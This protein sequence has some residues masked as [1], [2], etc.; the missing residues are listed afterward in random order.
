MNSDVNSDV[1]N[2]MKSN[3]NRINQ[4]MLALKESN[5]KA[6]V[7][8][9][10][11]GDPSPDIT[12]DAMHALVANGADIIELG[13]PFS[14]PMAEGPVIQR[15]HERALVHNVSL[16]STMAV[17]KQFRETDTETP[18]VLM[19]YANPI[20]RMG[21]SKFASIASDSG[22]DGVLTVDLPPEEAV[23]LNA[24]LKRVDIV[25]IFLLAPT[26]T[27]QRIREVVSLAS[28]FVYYVS[29]KGV[30]GAG[31]LDLKSVKDKLTL[32]R[33][34]TELPICVGFGIKDGESAKS[35]AEYADGAVVGSVFVDKM[36]TLQNESHDV[37]VSSIGQLAA[38]IRNG[39][40]S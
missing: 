24:E 5:K 13:I 39:L 23:G 9:I 17:V 14:D 26:T 3:M 11:S 27:V 21:Y 16:T 29:L 7:T 8:Y 25:N 2:D 20:E 1:N 34:H 31:N 32:I 22:V 18:V 35:V 30:T 37:I 36:G 15:A 19:G 38:G 6:L 40:D 33:Q 10:V 12:L 28:G 4:R